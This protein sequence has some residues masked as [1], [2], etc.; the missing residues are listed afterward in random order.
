[1]KTFLPI[2]IAVLLSLALVAERFCYARIDAALGYGNAF[3][4]GLF[5][6]FFTGSAGVYCLVTTLKSRGRVR[7]WSAIGGLICA[8]AAIVWCDDTLGD[9]YVDWMT[10]PDQARYARLAEMIEAGKLKADKD[11]VV[12]LPAEEAHA[13]NVDQASLDGSPPDARIE[14]SL[15][16]SYP[17]GLLI[18]YEP[19]P[20][21][22]LNE[23]DRIWWRRVSR[24]SAH[25]Y[26]V[27][28]ADW[29]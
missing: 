3:L 21:L 24:K 5:L 22:R 19:R 1:M 20:I 14:F 6:L 28:W 23:H 15:T 18:V 10:I 9:R 26:M 27:V 4:A 25:W 16:Y 29:D 17:G 11:G 12:K 7:G 8:F 2:R 13:I